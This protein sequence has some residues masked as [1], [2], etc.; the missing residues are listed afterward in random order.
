[1]SIL[2]CLRCESELIQR[3]LRGQGNVC[4]RSG[5]SSGGMI[6]DNK[7]CECLRAQNVFAHKREFVAFQETLRAN[8]SVP[9]NPRIFLPPCHNAH[10]SLLR[11]TLL[12]FFSF[13]FQSTFGN[14]KIII[15]V[16]S[17]IMSLFTNRMRK[18]RRVLINFNP[19]SLH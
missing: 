10:D 8:T 4:F 3:L 12:L 17:D 7:S 15:A 5:A 16:A 6:G 2:C 11:C 14:T 13:F 9:T 19:I 18:F 1:M